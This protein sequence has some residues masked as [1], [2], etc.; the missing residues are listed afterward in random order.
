MAGDT[1]GEI[2]FSLDLT[3]WLLYSIRENAPGS[4]HIEKTSLIFSDFYIIFSCLSSF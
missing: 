3:Y 4:L 2:F 1:I